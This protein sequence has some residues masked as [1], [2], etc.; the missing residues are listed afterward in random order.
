VKVDQQHPI[1]LLQLFPIP[2]WKWETISLDFITGLP[3][4]RKQHDSIMVVVDKFS[5]TTHFIFVKFTFKTVEIAEIFM[6][7]IF[8]LHGIPKV[9]ISDRNVKFTYT[10]WKTLF[11]GL[12]TEIQFSTAYHPQTDGHT[13]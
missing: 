11:A 13:E 5:K 4:T 7:E 8:W 10:F 9:V 6:K 12:G 1:G 3:C 2:E